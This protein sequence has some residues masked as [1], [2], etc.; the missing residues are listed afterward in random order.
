MSDIQRLID[1]EAIKQLKARY[2]RFLDT[3]DWAG[4]SSVFTLDV[5]LMVPEGDVD[6]TG[7][8][9]VVEAISSLLAGVLTVHQGHMPEIQITGPDTASGVWAMFDYLDFPT[10]DGTRNGMQGYGHYHERYAREADAW[11]ISEL[12]L[13]RLRVDSLS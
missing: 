8:N 13:T 6:V 12:L 1:I 3:K 2:F 5:H 10:T 9:A 7:R 11:R 4:F